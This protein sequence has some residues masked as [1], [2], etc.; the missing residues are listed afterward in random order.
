MRIA[1]LLKPRY[2]QPIKSYTIPFYVLDINTTPDTITPNPT[3]LN[4]DKNSPK[5]IQ[6][7]ID[8]TTYPKLNK[9]KA[10]LSGA[11]ANATSQKRELETKRTTPT[12]I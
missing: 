1:Q 10:K 4:V 7:R 6:D 12:K 8:T 11:R 5:N 3:I 9:G 2:L